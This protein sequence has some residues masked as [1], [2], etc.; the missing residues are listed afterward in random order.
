VT[1]LLFVLFVASLL[2]IAGKKH[3]HQPRR[4]SNSRF[5]GSPPQN[6]KQSGRHA[7]ERR[8][9]M[10]IQHTSVRSLEVLY[11]TLVFFRGLARSEGSQVSTFT[12][13][14]IRLP[15]I[16]AILTGLQFSDHASTRGKCIAISWP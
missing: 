10:V 16:Q 1:A 8:W 12:G 9:P 2:G 3:H 14:G 15:G 5:H 4:E 11:S 6:T 7:S 13:L